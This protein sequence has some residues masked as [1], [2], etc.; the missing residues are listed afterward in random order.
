MASKRL[1]PRPPGNPFIIG[2]PAEGENI[3]DRVNE[4]A[5]IGRGFGDP[6]SRLVVYGDRRMGKTS[7]VGAAALAAESSGTPVAVV[8]LGKV[9]SAEAA[10]QRV[11]S[12]VHKTIGTR[13]RDAAM[14]LVNRMR[15]GS[16]SLSGGVDAQGLP[17]VS[18]SVA[19]VDARAEKTRLFTD[20]L[21]AVEAELES[22]DLTMGLALD[23]FQRL[24]LWC[25]EEIDWPLKAVLERHRRIS[26]V[27]AGSER[28]LIDQMLDNKKAGLWKL[29]EI[30][31]IQPIPADIFTSWLVSR[32]ATTGTQFGDDVA[33]KIIRLA[34]PRSRDV[35]QL[36]RV[37][38]DRVQGERTAT[39]D[40]VAAAM[41]QLVGEQESLYLREWTRLA[42]DVDRKILA[43]LADDAHT[44]IMALA[45]MQHYK[46]GPKTSVHRALQRLIADEVVVATQDAHDFDDPFFRRWV[47][48]NALEDIGRPV[49][50]LL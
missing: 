26:Y 12:A 36:A 42:S 41:D 16:V 14:S 19:P 20:V 32:A 31:D 38:W 4:I 33:A 7:V 48:L 23:E 9:T 28:A 27:L 15:P 21:D 37:L 2:H 47:Q 13:W 10:A 11:L 50:L 3:A 49:P 43:L 30:V 5:R 22:R 1:P 39:L 24:R 40:D 25:A 44:E 17:T 18:F 46:L 8:D 45:T 6:S 34:G 35:V 29:V